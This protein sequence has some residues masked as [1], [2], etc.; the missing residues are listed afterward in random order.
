MNFNS[1]YGWRILQWHNIYIEFCAKQF[2]GSRVEREDRLKTDT[3]T[4]W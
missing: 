2:I 1:N 4:V 3:C